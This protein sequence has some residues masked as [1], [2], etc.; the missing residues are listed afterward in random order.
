MANNNKN[1]KKHVHEILLIL[2]HINFAESIKYS[3]MY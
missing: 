3:T 2:T 1:Y